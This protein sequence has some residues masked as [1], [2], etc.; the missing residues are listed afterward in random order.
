MHP[1]FILVSDP[2][3]PLVGTFVYG[4]VGQHRDLVQAYV[5]VHS[6]VKVHG[7]GWYLKDDKA[8]TIT[9][10]GGSGDYGDPRLAFLNRIPSELK[11]YKFIY[12]PVFGLPGNE[13]ELED[14][15]WV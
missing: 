11:G 9:L 6:Y 3:T 13:L 10:Y 7:G 1:K 12:T 8:R 14:V 2:R 5:D 15:E 4:M